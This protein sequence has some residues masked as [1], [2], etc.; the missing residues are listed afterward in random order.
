MMT[1]MFLLLA[2]VV[3]AVGSVLHFT[4]LH[5]R[6]DPLG[7]LIDTTRTAFAGDD[8]ELANVHL[9]LAE[10]KLSDFTRL[11][12]DNPNSPYLAKLSKDMVNQDKQAIAYMDKAKQ[13][14]QDLRKLNLVKRLCDTLGQQD[15][16]LASANSEINSMHSF[17]EDLEHKV[18]AGQSLSTAIDVV[19]KNIADAMKW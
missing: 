16:Q 8:V 10:N 11:R 9:A 5:Y 1:K 13:G 19:K 12:K 4:P 17:A 3:V 2:V 15:T 18:V 7:R 6:L 14:G